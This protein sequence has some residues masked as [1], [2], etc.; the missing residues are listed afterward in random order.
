MTTQTEKAL[1]SK[2]ESMEKQQLNILNNQI[3]SQKQLSGIYQAL[4]MLLEPSEN[5]SENEVI[6]LLKEIKEKLDNKQ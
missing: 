4:V 2:L 5:G 6:K 1:L 3:E